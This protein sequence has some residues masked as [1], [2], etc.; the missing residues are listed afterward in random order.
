MGSGEEER[1][2][3]GEGSAECGSRKS[4]G[5]RMVVEVVCVGVVRCKP[6]RGLAAGAVV[7][8]L[9]DLTVRFD[10][11]EEDEELPS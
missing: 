5:P 2:G 10:S 4:G 8:P 9:E 7:D 3:A 11:V 1:E 6:T